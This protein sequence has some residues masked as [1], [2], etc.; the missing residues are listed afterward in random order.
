MAIDTSKKRILGLDQSLSN[1]GWA[2]CEFEKNT[3]DFVWAYGCIK[4]KAK[5]DIAGRLAD[6]TSRIG[7]L[8]DALSP[9]IVIF[10]EV[11]CGRNRNVYMK[12]LFVLGSLMAIVG[13]KNIE[14]KI[15]AA[16]T[17]KKSSWR[18]PLN[19]GSEKNEAYNK[20]IANFTEYELN[21]HSAE[22]LCIV[23]SELVDNMGVSLSKFQYFNQNA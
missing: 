13:S 19:L 22:A 9:D 3:E 20:L 5:D 10:E 2:F 1:T 15:K 7:N 21:E 18:H 6:I 14:Y 12:L 4:T 16:G 23:H 17:K 8:I 11:F